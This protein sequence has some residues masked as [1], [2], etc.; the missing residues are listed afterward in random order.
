QR[1]PGERHRARRLA[2]VRRKPHINIVCL[3]DAQ[4]E[5]GDNA[6]TPTATSLDGEGELKSSRCI[7]FSKRYKT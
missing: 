1:D 3:P 2:P 4:D 7:T 6:L 5:G